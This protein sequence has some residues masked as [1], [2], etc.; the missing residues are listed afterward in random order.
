MQE[1]KEKGL[2]RSRDETSSGSPSYGTV[3]GRRKACRS[4]SGGGGGRGGG[5]GGGSVP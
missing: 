5:G 1:Q 3:G 2:M 4:R